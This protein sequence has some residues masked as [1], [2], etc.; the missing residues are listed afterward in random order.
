M[1][2]PI[3]KNVMVEEDF[4]GVKVDVCKN[5]CKG[6][7]FDWKEIVELDESHE[8]FD[9]ALKEALNSSHSKDVNRGKINCPKC[10][11]PMIAHLYQSAKLVTVDECYVCGGF[12]LDSGELKLIRENFM[13]EEERVVY[14]NEILGEHPAFDELKKD[15][16]KERRRT[17]AV[18]KF[19]EILKTN[20]IEKLI[21]R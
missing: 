1:N 4:G 10:N 14:I 6:L 5:G 8:G 7:W 9:N 11:T 15:L 20:V 21:S 18:K 3:C 2:C 17:Q 19:S 12:F 13:S 16:G